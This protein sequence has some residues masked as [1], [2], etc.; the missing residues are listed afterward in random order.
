MRVVG[1][2]IVGWWCCHEESRRFRLMRT[3]LGEE[4]VDDEDEDEEEEH[5][6][7][8]ASRSRASW[9]L[10]QRILSA[11]IRMKSFRGWPRAFWRLEGR[12]EVTRA[13]VESLELVDVNGCCCSRRVPRSPW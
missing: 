10:Y 3:R 12:G 9:V 5:D 6:A 11:E 1:W 13:I 2:L 8:E 4:D 7:R